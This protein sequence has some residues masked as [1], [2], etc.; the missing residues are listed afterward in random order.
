MGAG[1][2]MSLFPKS[3]LLLLLGATTITGS[4][5][6]DW[7]WSSWSGYPNRGSGHHHVHDGHYCTRDAL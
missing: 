1:E 5:G 7:N 3:L 2:M 4:R 6:Q